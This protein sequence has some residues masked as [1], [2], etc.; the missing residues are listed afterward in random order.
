MENILLVDDSAYLRE[1]Y[2]EG[3]DI[4]GHNVYLAQD[5]QEAFD[6]LGQVF[7]TLDVIIM[8]IS[9]PGMNGILASEKILAIWSGIIIIYSVHCTEDY[10]DQFK[11][12]G[13]RYFLAKPAK[14]AQLNRAIKRAIQNKEEIKQ[15]QIDQKF[16]GLSI[17]DLS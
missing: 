6:V 5:A 10:I 3:L 2:S 8:D 9:M 14:L 12:V 7:D 17:C 16:E 1:V 11:K 15:D 13:I 4:L